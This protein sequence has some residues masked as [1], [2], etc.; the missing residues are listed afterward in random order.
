MGDTL[1][2]PLWVVLMAHAAIA[3]GTLAGGWRIVRT[4]GTRVTHLKPVH[5]FSA[6]TASGLVLL[7][8]AHFG[9]PVSTTHAIS[10]SVMGVGLAQRTLGVRWIL[11]RRILWAWILTIP[12]SSLI[13]AATY[14][15]LR[16]FQF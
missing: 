3:L 15:L 4:L 12:A 9:I 10:G 14:F 1:Y 5:G 13:A 7:T 6:E 8:T 2:I 16:L 11:A